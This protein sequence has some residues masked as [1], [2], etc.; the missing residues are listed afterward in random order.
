[1]YSSLYG[2][3]A[4]VVL[5]FD[6][7]TLW[8]HEMLAENGFWHKIALKFI[9]GHSLCNELQA[10]KGL[11]IVLLAVSPKFSKTKPAKSTNIAVVDHPTL[12]WRPRQ[13]EPPRK[14]P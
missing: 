6:I 9:Q 3:I 14:S 13:E 1:M 5:F 2:K 8:I 10:D 12:I 7:Q 4:E 11:H